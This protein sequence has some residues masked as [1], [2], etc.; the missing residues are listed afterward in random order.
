MIVRMKKLSFLVFYK[1][2]QEF[3]EKIRDLGVIHVIENQQGAIND[4]A[5]QDKMQKLAR[6]A[7]VMETLEKMVDK[8]SL[9]AADENIDFPSLLAQWDQY[10]LDKA[11]TEAR[12]QALSKD[13]QLLAPW[14]DFD[15]SSI[16]LLEK[17]GYCINFFTCASRAFKLEWESEFNALSIANDKSKL[18]FITITK[19]EVELTIDAELCRLPKLSLAA[20]REELSALQSALQA[21]DRDIVAFAQQHLNDFQAAYDAL[22]QDIDF[23]KVALSADAVADSKVML[24]QGWAPEKSFPALS[25]YL[26]KNG[27]F[28]QVDDPTQEDDI[29][30]QLSNN[31]FFR[32]FEPLT[33]LYM[34]P[35]YGELDLTMFFA[36][37]FMLFFGLC[38]GD[39]GYG[40]LIM[41]ALPIFTKL[42][43][44]INPEFKSTLVFL[45]GLSTVLAG[46]LTG[47]AFG[48]SLYDIDL[49]F[50]QKMK[51]LLYQDNQA[52]F[53][54]SLII[55]CVQILF[56]MILK[57]V[58]LGIQL[59][60]KYAISTIGWILLLV[61]VALAVLTGS[62]GSIWFIVVM[63]VA[64]CMVL[65]YNSPGKNIFLNFGLG[66][67]DAYNMV[68]GLLGD[69]L[70]YVRL[71][72][73]GLSGGIL[74][75][76]FNSLATGMS[77]DIPVVG[78]LVTALIFVIGHGLN[79]FMNILGS[80]VHPMR[81]TF[82]EFF[83]NSGYEGG[84]RAYKPF[85]K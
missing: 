34:L 63:A 7:S 15:P 70:S 27:Y 45:F 19:P 36:P 11:A 58:N 83:K 30:I 56:G 42:F 73:L 38:L 76:V 3:L 71:F 17:Q 32:L 75:S 68:T 79:I 47:T 16:E 61:G 25:E 10:Q 62:T 6:Y 67:W 57:A 64:G 5:V 13:E 20:L 21:L 39:M 43:Q 72:A 35:K 69:V 74:A 65:F 14:G 48:F 29:P 77:P 40:A 23:S 50:F 84:G 55:G 28:Y 49:P 37:F 54:L 2:Y 8:K 9:P 66:L 53:Y 51:D 31:R 26:D 24:L 44:L 59:G 46:T 85:K 4:V 33:K 81:L 78:F 82:V 60:F 22:Q 52:M 18:Y 41:L 1:E 80:M 12:I